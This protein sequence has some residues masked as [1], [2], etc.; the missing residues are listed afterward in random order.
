[1]RAK[2]PY[3][4]LRTALFRFLQHYRRLDMETSERHAFW[5]PPWCENHDIPKSKAYEEIAAGELVT[6]KIGRRRYITAEES[7]RYFQ[8][9]E[10]QA[11]EVS[12]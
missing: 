2:C 8:R 11:R 6:F 1:M 10:R 5:L 12:S 3:L 4:Y 7:R 9:K